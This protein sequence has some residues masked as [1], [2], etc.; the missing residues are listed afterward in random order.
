[1]SECNSRHPKISD[2]SIPVSPEP[3]HQCPSKTHDGTNA[4]CD[5]IW[6]IDASQ[7]QSKDHHK[8]K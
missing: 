4:R 7:R 3:H 6:S 5:S 8:I 2:W 1:M